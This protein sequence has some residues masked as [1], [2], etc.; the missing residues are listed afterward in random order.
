VNLALIYSKFPTN[1]ET[2]ILREAFALLE[3]G[4]TLHILS[5]KP[6]NEAVVHS[7]AES[8]LPHTTYLP[9]LLSGEVLSAVAYWAWRRPGTLLRHVAF[10]LRG[11]SRGPRETLNNLALMPKAMTFA[12]RLGGRRI[13]FVHG[14]WATYPAT[15]ARLVGELLGVPWGFSA[16][17][18]DIYAG[19]ALLDDKLRETRLVLTCTADNVKYLHGRVPAAAERVFLMYHGLDLDHFHPTP[20]PPD[21]PLRILCPGTLVHRKGQHLLVRAVAELVRE[22]VDCRLTLV[23]ADGALSA[24]GDVSQGSQL[25]RVQRMVAELGL[26]DRVRH[27]GFTPESKMAAFYRECHVVALPALPGLHFGLPNVLIEAMASAR[28]FVCTA[29]PAVE[30]ALADA[31]VGILLPRGTEDEIAASTRDALRRLARDPALRA[32]LGER[33][34]ATVAHYGSRQCGRELV[35]RFEAAAAAAAPPASLLD[36]A[37]ARG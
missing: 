10:T 22:G 36:R 4:T 35:Q 32:S 20:L 6:S 13:D 24:A 31:G 17:A 34:P 23:G 3:S 1:D 11:L 9:W 12:R 19:N 25:E 37:P 33:G 16:H 28:P 8:L 7:K 18:H 5:L 30:G 15:A 27:V 21:G 2:F 26:G 14:L 29:L